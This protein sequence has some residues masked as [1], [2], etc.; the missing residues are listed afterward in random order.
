[1]AQ[2]LIVEG[3]DAIVLARLCQKRGL[4]PPLGYETAEK[5]KADFVAVANGYSKTLGLLALAIQ[6]ADL[7]NIGII[8]DANDAGAAARWQ[9]IRTILAQKYAAETLTA[10]DA[11]VGA[12]VIVEANLP[13]VGVWIMP[14]NVGLGYLE[15]FLADLVRTG[16]P[17]WQHAVEQVA[18]L[19]TKPFCELTAAKIGKA[20]LHTW[21]AWK[22]EPGKPFGQALDADYLDAYAPAAQPFL[23]WFV[24]TFQLASA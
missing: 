16:E 20:N 6:Q 19:Q 24:A 15:T 21:L 10:A 11:Q 2:K 23:D 14:D 13:T 7:T 3:N 22:P 4:Q 17:L 18:D 9:A 12:K 8:V 5:F 1:M